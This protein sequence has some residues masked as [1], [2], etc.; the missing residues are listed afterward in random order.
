MSAFFWGAS[1]A[2]PGFARAVP[3]VKPQA[4]L[5]SIGAPSFEA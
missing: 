5:N 2:K 1:R 4:R 3:L